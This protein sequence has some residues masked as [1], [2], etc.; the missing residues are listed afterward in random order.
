MKEEGGVRGSEL[1]NNKRGEG[2][3]KCE[4]GNIIK[5][6]GEGIQKSSWATTQTTIEGRTNMGIIAFL[7]LVFMH[8]SN[9]PQNT[10]K[11]IN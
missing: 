7:C 3:Q 6:R 10:S 9:Y 1:D 5:Q 4:E 11:N 2:M 8:H